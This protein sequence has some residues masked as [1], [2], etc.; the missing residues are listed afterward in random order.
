MKKSSLLIFLLSLLVSVYSENIRLSNGTEYVNITVIGSDDA[1]ITIDHDKGTSRIK[2]SQMS[3]DL[4]QKYGYSLEKEQKYYQKLDEDKKVVAEQKFQKEEKERKEIESRNALLLKLKTDASEFLEKGSICAFKSTFYTDVAGREYAN[5]EKVI[6]AIEYNNYLL[7][8]N[9]HFVRG[10][11]YDTEPVVQYFKNAKVDRQFKQEF[12]DAKNIVSQYG[13]YKNMRK[14]RDF[15]INDYNRMAAAN[16]KALLSRKQYDVNLNTN[17]YTYVTSNISY[18]DYR[19]FNNGYRYA[20][21]NSNGYTNSNTTGTVVETTPL[22][23]SFE[24]MQDVSNKIYNVCTGMDN[25]S[26]SVSRSLGNIN[27]NVNILGGWK[28]D[29]AYVALDKFRHDG[30]FGLYNTQKPCVKISEINFIKAI[31]EYYTSQDVKSTVK[32]L[33]QIYQEINK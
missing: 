14:N 13:V 7:M 20:T 16:Q 15:L 28:L 9:G 30:S 26:N 4:K 8:E 32:S 10:G 17:S 12:G 3:S 6:L 19:S 5:R 31:E 11:F 24:C 2:F 1:S 18:S 33:S 22:P 29:C 21:T 25:Y 23:Y 27:N